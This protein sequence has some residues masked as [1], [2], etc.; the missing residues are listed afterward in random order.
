MGFA[1][2]KWEEMQEIEE[3]VNL[4]EELG[5]TADELEET[6]YWVEIDADSEGYT[7]GRIVYFDENAPKSIL[8][9]ISGLVDGSYV[10]LALYSNDE[11]EEYERYE[12]QYRHYMESGNAYAAFEF[13][14]E[15]I[16][17][18]NKL[19]ITDINLQ[20][21]FNRQLYISCITLLETLLSD[22]FLDRIET[23]SNEKKL[24]VASHKPFETKIKISS[25]YKTFEELDD[26][27]RK[28]IF[29]ISFH[30]LVTAKSLYYSVFRVTLPDTADLLR[31]VEVRH[32]LVHRNGKDKE[33]NRILISN[34]M[35]EQLILKVGNFGAEVSRVIESKKIVDD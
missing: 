14:L 5:I 15:D 28:E 1:K 25:I 34:E 20:Q 8:E 3:I 23:N 24:F 12:S 29:K 35:I 7:R 30:N 21:P 11:K 18:L 13:G 16:M 19:N 31:N 26:I 27:I 6:G 32:N 4:A 33:G 17:A 22:I 2:R 10:E 9:K